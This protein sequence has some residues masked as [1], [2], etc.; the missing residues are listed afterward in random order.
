MSRKELR[1]R[2]SA[3]TLAWFA[4]LSLGGLFVLA[5]PTFAAGDGSSSVATGA[6]ISALKTASG[7]CPGLTPCPPKGAAEG[8]E[9][10]DDK[11]LKPA[12]QTALLSVLLNV[13]QFALDRLAYEA[14]VAIASGGEGQSELFYSD[15]PGE[16]WKKFGLDIAGEAIG[17]LSDVTDAAQSLLRQ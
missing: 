15:K 11:L 3:A 16:A 17:Q 5:R 7:A 4:A 6:I 10:A 13:V 1:K 9:T 12:L 2:L 8:L 14:A